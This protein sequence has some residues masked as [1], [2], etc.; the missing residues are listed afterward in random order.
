M[1]IGI[2]IAINLYRKQKRKLKKKE[3]RK[4]MEK[5]LAEK[6]Y[7]KKYGGLLNAINETTI[8]FTI[9]E[10]KDLFYNYKFEGGPNYDK[11]NALDKIYSTL[12]DLNGFEN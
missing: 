11:S 6:I 3:K 2:E 9:E 8:S 4:K 10:M 12:K 1:I 5:T 7:E